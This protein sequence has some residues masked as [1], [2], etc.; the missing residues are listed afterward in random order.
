[1]FTCALLQLLHTSSDHRP[2]VLTDAHKPAGDNDTSGHLSKAC[3]LYAPPHYQALTVTSC[4]CW[5]RPLDFLQPH[6]DEMGLVEEFAQDGRADVF[7][8]PHDVDER[9]ACRARTWAET[10]HMRRIHFIIP[11][12][13]TQSVQSGSEYLGVCSLSHRLTDLRDPIQNPRAS[14]E[15]QRRG[16]AAGNTLC[17]YVYSHI[18][19]WRVN[20]Q[21]QITSFFFFSKIMFFVHSN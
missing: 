7:I 4:F 1:M 20:L 12:S 8:F 14:D 19:I 21:K 17:V 9:R 3:L 10:P 6:E 11:R 13:L 2:V 18:Y 5:A 16:W 15:T